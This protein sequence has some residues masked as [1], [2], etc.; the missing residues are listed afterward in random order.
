M[1][2]GLVFLGVAVCSCFAPFGIAK[3]DSYLGQSI[4]VG[5]TF[6]PQGYADANGQ[7][8]PIAQ[9]PD[10]AKLYGTTYGGDGKTTFAL[11]DLRGRVP[12]SQGAAKGLPTATQGD[13]FGTPTTTLTV[14]QMPQHSHDFNASLSDAALTDPAGALL[15]TGKVKIYDSTQGPPVAMAKETIGLAGGGQPFDQYQPTLVIRYCIALTG[16]VPPKP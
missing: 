4:L 12:V 13:A 14:Q 11:P 1:K 9:N 15:T 8:L 3:S 10:L 6:C 5:Y 7:L 2:R 16:I